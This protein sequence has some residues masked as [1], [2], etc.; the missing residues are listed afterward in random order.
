MPVVSAVG[1]EIDFTISDF[2]A[3]YRAGWRPV[4]QRKSSRPVRWRLKIHC[5][6]PAAACSDW[7]RSAVPENRNASAHW[8]TVCRCHPRRRLQE[9]MQRIDELHDDLRGQR[10]PFGNTTNADGELAERLLRVRPELIVARQQAQLA[11]LRDRLQERPNARSVE[12]TAGLSPW[13]S[14]AFAG[15]E[16][17]GPRLF[18]YSGC[19]DRRR[20]RAA[21]SIKTAKSYPPADGEVESTADIH[22]GRDGGRRRK[23]HRCQR[24]QK[25][26]RRGH[27]FEAAVGKLE[28]I[29]EAM[30]SEESCWK[31]ARAIRGRHEAGEDL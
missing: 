15:P 31:T 2:T 21:N 3:D 18:H 24:R 14:V 10:N 9:Q 5:K 8:H 20:L 16:N 29:V 30:E 23:L 19:E 26:G 25:R 4:R 22:A 17:A 27:H 28:S 13:R 1:H 12:P 6:P 11:Q 7:Q